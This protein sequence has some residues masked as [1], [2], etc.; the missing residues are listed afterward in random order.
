MIRQHQLPQS[1][2]RVNEWTLSRCRSQTA[3]EVG[4]RVKSSL[5]SQ[6]KIS[7]NIKIT[8]NVSLE[9]LSTEDSPT[10]FSLVEENR[11]QLQRFLYWVDEVTDLRTTEDYIEKRIHSG[12]PGAKWFK[13]VL[14]HEP[15]GVFG[16]KSVC[17]EK[18]EAEIGFWLSQKAQGK[19]LISQ[20]ISAVSELLKQQNIRTLK[21][22]CLHENKASIAVAKR[23]GAVHT[24]TEPNYLNIDGQLQDLQIYTLQL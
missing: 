20:A 15:A 5:D 12:L 17:T 24:G 8:D 10:I 16:I 18:S 11:K 9:Q 13:V 6:N 4:R 21:M 19:G 23:A 7:M 2:G 14:M 3:G 22:T 1:S